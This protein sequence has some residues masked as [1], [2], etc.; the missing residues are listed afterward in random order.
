VRLLGGNRMISIVIPAYNEE[1]NLEPLYSKLREVLNVAGDDDFEVIF[2]DD[3][4]TDPT[5]DAC[6][7]CACRATSAIKA[8]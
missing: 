8:R 2:V 5:W 4:S 3:G 7:A 1:R 6:A